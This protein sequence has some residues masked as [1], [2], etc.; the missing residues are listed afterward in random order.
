MVKY[1]PLF[2][3]TNQQH[4]SKQQNQI[5]RPSGNYTANKNTDLNCMI[6]MWHCRNALDRCRGN[7]CESQ[8]RYREFRL[9]LIQCRHRCPLLFHKAHWGHKR[10]Y[11]FTCMQ[12]HTKICPNVWYPQRC[13]KDPLQ[14]QLSHLTGMPTC[15][16]TPISSWARPN[17][18]YMDTYSFKCGAAQFLPSFKFWGKIVSPRIG[19]CLYGGQV[20]PN[21]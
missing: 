14:T 15:P 19:K 5:N 12:K 11:N 1:E 10:Y 18:P 17:S 21:Q 3:Q 7:F 2:L 16:P 9:T 13:N 4:T 20:T 8:M 6:A